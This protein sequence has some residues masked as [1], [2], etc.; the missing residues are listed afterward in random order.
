MSIPEARIEETPAG[1]VPAATAGSSSASIG[2]RGFATEGHGVFCP[3]ESPDADFEDFGLNVH[4]LQPG[5]RSALYHA[6]NVQE[7]FL[8]LAG[9]CIAVVEEEERRLRA[10]DYLHCPAGT[11]HGLIG[12]GDGPC[13]ILMVGARK[14]D[15]TMHYPVSDVAAAPRA[16]D[17]GRERRRRARRTATRAGAARARRR[18]CPGRA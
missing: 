5:E 4:V 2:A 14:P 3:F 10:W 11:R 7:G 17:A 6:E 18:R 15:A 13:A 12:A 9:E 8:V 16:L 1:R